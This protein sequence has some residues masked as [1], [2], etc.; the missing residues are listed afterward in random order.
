MESTQES[1]LKFHKGNTVIVCDS[2]VLKNKRV[3][4]M[5]LMVYF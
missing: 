3:A 5:G 2:T 1:S 4:P